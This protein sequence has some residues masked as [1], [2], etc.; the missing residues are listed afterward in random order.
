MLLDIPSS[1]SDGGCRGDAVIG[2]QS[3]IWV[4]FAMKIITRTLDTFPGTQKTIIFR[5]TGSPDQFGEMNDINDNWIWNWLFTDSGAGNI[6][7]TEL[8][9]VSSRL[10]AWNTYKL[11]Y[12]FLGSGQ[13]TTITF[14]MNGT[15]VLR[16]IHTTHDQ[17]GI[18]D[19]VTF[20]GTLN[21]GSG[22]SK[23]AFDEIHIGS[24]DPGW[25]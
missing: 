10:G 7:L 12:H 21:G 2:S 22:A 16:T 20:G 23:F 9:S 17:A 5:N 24:T 1:G 25:P 13:G 3:D 6:Y 11:H 18:P 14:G 8:G 15:N 19:R 4:V